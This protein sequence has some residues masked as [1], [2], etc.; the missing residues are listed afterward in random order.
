MDE[1]K[2]LPG[3]MGECT[4]KQVVP[5]IYELINSGSVDKIGDPRR[6]HGRIPAQRFVQI[7]VARLVARSANLSGL[8]PW[9][10]FMRPQV[11]KIKVPKK[12]ESYFVSIHYANRL[13]L[14]CGP[15]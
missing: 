2:R 11:R 3:A 5:N 13:A 10:C 12:Q 9:S 8:T 4:S 7:N 14:N 1:T 6:F 15:S